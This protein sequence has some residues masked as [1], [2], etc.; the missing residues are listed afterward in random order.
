MANLVQW[1]VRRLS[2]PVTVAAFLLVG[3]SGVLMYFHLDRGVLHRMHPLAGLTLVVGGL[4]HALKNYRSLLA[5]LK[6]AEA[7][8]ASGIVLAVGGGLAGLALY[9]TLA[10]PPQTGPRA[11]DMLGVVAN[12]PLFELA[13]IIGTDVADIEARLVAKGITVTS[14]S[15]TLV[16]LARIANVTRDDAI[17]AVLTKVGG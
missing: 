6:R 13:P 11:R 14:S 2:T 8:V 16:D 7:W 9:W 15:A 10:K 12:A 5:Y 17:I 1:V 4:L 3:C